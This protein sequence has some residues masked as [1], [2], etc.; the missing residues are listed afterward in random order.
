M[1]GHK[2]DCI[3]RGVDYPL[4]RK[5]KELGVDNFLIQ[6]VEEYP[7]QSKEELH[8]R[9]GEWIKQEKPS[10]NKTML[11]EH[12]SNIMWIIKNIMRK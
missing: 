11:V 10:L 5:M 8:K 4:Y 9:E 7:C 3:K 1:A 6:L 2:Q 12:I